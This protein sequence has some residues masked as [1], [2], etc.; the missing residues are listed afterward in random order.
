MLKGK[1]L[2]KKGFGIKSARYFLNSKE[3]ISHKSYF[4]LNKYNYN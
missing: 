1:Y 3:I 2:H 4:G